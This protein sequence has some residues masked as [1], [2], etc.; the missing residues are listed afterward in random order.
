ME[1]IDVVLSSPFKRAIDTIQ[2]FADKNGLHYENFEKIR[3]LM[4]WVVKFVFEDDRCLDIVQYNV[5]EM[6]HN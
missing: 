1:N 6:P 3:T 2:E 4:P 5:F